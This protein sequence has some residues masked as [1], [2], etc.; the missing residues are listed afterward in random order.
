MLNKI[1]V[2]IPVYNIEQYVEECI[3]SIIN[4]TYDY[5][6]VIVIDDGSTDNSGLICDSLAKKDSRISVYHKANGGLASAR[7][8]GISKASGEW[9]IHVD[10]DD[11][12]EPNALELLFETAVKSKSEI[13]F[14]N[15]RWVYS[16]HVMYSKVVDWTGNKM[17]DLN[18]YISSGWV[19]LANPLIHRK[20]YTSYGIKSP[21]GISMCEDFYVIVPLCYHADRITTIHY[22]LYNY[23]QRDSSIIRTINPKNE[24][25]EISVYVFVINYF[26]KIGVIDEYKKSMSWRML[27]ALQNKVLYIENFAAINKLF[28]IKKNFIFDCPFIGFKIKLLFWL[29]THKLE[30]IAAFFIKIRNTV[31]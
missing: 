18:N 8:Y 2:I 10:G 4:Q 7:N 3:T 13:V 5:I 19:R 15:E 22:P 14:C 23:R 11:W 12:L 27:K 31:R 17:E 26:E 9:I 1:S 24:N 30:I 6:E 25:D 21:E 29:V 16:D 20:L 28:P